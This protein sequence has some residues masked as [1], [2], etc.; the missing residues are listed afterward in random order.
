[1]S[2]HVLLTL[3]KQS[4]KSN[5]MRRLLSILSLFCNKF[6]KEVL[7]IRCIFSLIDMITNTKFQIVLMFLKLV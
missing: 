1:M 2:S 5:K 3:L 6:N 4:G 7:A